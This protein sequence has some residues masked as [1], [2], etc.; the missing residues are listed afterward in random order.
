MRVNVQLI[1][2]PMTPSWAETFDH[3][4]TDIFHR[5]ESDITT[6]ADELSAK[7]TGREEQE[8][9]AKP[10]DNLGSHDLLQSEYDFHGPKQ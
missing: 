7:L 3:K 9:A 4:L 5:S 2:H 8:I 6:I 1:K 10:T